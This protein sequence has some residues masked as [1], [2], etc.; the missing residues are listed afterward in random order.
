MQAK[1]RDRDR[2]IYQLLVE[3]GELT[4]REKEMHREKKKKK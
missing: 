3:F 4:E 1:E 2:G